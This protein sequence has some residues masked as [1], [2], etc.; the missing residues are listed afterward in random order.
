MCNKKSNYIKKYFYLFFN[1]VTIF[2]NKILLIYILLL[3][4]Y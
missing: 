4:Y 2:F 1:T 3:I